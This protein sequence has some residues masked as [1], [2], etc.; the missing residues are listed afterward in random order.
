MS[1][2]LKVI[3]DDVKP[4]HETWSIEI[5][6]GMDKE[7]FISELKKKLFE[8]AYEYIQNP[9]IDELADI[10][11]VIQELC[12]QEL[13]LPTI[14]LENAAQTKRT[15]RGSFVCRTGMYAVTDDV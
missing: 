6:S 10:Y 15:K 5:K 7:L 14:E 11:E 3:R 4:D 13:D 12:F 9:C 8:E 2:L 1:R